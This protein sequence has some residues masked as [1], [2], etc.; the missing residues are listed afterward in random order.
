MMFVFVNVETVNYK[1]MMNERIIVS[2][3]TWSKRIHNIPAVLDTIFSQT[4]S[5]DGVVLNLSDG[6]I[7][8]QVVKDYIENKSVEIHFVPDT[9]VYKKLLPTLKRYPNDCVISIDDDW[10]YPINMV[11]DFVHV[12]QI[13][14]NNPISGNRAVKHELQC[15]CGCASLMK[16]SFLGD[17]L[18]KI[19]D[20]VMSNCPS[21][22]IVYTYFANKAGY[23]YVRTTDE[24]F[25]NMIPYNSEESYS[26]SSVDGGGIEKSFQYLVDKFGPLPQFV[27]SYIPDKELA[28]L[29]YDIYVRS[30]QSEFVNGVMEGRNEI[31]K[32]LRYRIGNL[33]VSPISKVMQPWN[34]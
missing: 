4:L 26:G 31:Y 28:D 20:E 2:M 15:H 29:L 1:N 24:Y 8:P 6:E 13:Y 14:P 16:A 23:P 21:D 17:F 7:I 18:D 12:H 3:T 25:M 32:S 27:S 9:K 11:E 22:D 5:P 30:A 34:K 19:D 10:L 33:L